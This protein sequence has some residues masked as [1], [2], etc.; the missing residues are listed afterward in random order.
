M[1]SPP[2]PAYCYSSYSNTWSFQHVFTEGNPSITV[3]LPHDDDGADAGPGRGDE[4]GKK[5]QLYLSLLLFVLSLS[6]NLRL[7]FPSPLPPSCCLSTAIRICL[8]PVLTEF[9]LIYTNHSSPLSLLV[10]RDALS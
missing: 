7:S 9:E 3:D 10:L 6:F 1:N 4:S 5:E 8:R 2:P